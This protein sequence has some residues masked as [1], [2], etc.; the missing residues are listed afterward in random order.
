MTGK[1]QRRQTFLIDDDSQFLLEFADQTL[2]RTLSGFNL[3]AG[4]L[5][6]A[7]HRFTFRT[8]GEKHTPVGIDERTGGDK[9]KIHIHRSGLNLGTAGKGRFKL[10]TFIAANVAMV[11]KHLL[12]LGRC[13]GLSSA[14][15]FEYGFGEDGGRFS[16][17]I[18][19]DFWE[20]AVLIR[21]GEKRAMRFG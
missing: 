11:N 16:R 18:M 5:P 6:K 12:Y 19:P 2:F 4:K 13:G 7:G 17:G 1:S 8:L 9:D 15:Q 20:N 3:A 14:D 21:P 10:L